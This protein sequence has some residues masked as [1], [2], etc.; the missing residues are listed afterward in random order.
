[1]QH[2]STT[3][4]WSWLAYISIPPLWT[5]LQ[6]L[7]LTQCEIDKSAPKCWQY[8]INYS[9][10]KPLEETWMNRNTCLCRVLLP[11]G[12]TVWFIEQT[13]AKP[14]DRPKSVTKAK[15]TQWSRKMWRQCDRFHCCL[16]PIKRWR[17]RW[18]R[19]RRFCCSKLNGSLL[20]FDLK[21]FFIENLCYLVY[22]TRRRVARFG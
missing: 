9:D 20:F 21:R 3:L 7:A 1:M 17:R 10:N 8:P 19:R 4:S 16:G 6:L 15:C 22:D 12:P 18:R 2:Y 11:L 14:L 5:Q 13:Q